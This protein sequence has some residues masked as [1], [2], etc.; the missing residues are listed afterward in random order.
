MEQNTKLA[1]NWKSFNVPAMTASLTLFIMLLTL[2]SSFV[3]WRERV[4]AKFESLDKERAN[5]LVMYNKQMDLMTSTMQ[6]T[7]ALSQKT[8]Y[9]LT[10]AEEG[11]KDNSARMDRM[12]DAV[13]DLRDGIAGVKTSVEVLTEQVKQAIPFHKGELDYPP[14]E[15]TAR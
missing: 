9:R 5:N 14:K 2:W 6:A 7:A 1:V 15:L 4:D 11:I 8:D 13:G 10:V 12:A 3:A